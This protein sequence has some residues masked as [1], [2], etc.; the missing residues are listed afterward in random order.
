MTRHIEINYG[1]P[2]NKMC[3]S[4][5]LTIKTWKYSSKEKHIDFLYVDN[6]CIKLPLFILNRLA[7]RIY[8]DTI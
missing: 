2:N 6:S 1:H 8:D 7:I 5:I 3:G 4:I